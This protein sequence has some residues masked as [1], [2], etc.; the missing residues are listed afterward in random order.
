MSV[1]D[2]GPDRTTYTYPSSIYFILYP[3]ISMNYKS[4]VNGGVY[5]GI[6]AAST[7][8]LASGLD[9]D[10]GSHTRPQDLSAL[11]DAWKV[12]PEGLFAHVSGNEGGV[13]YGRG[14]RSDHLY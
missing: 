11:S 8:S 13:R 9:M 2:N 10:G 7:T 1:S 5:V 3:V 4:T 12:A 14:C 6:L